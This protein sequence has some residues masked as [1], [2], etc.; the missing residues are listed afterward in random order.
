ML[1]GEA[2]ACLRQQLDWSIAATGKANGDR[3]GVYACYDIAVL[4]WDMERFRSAR[5]TV[6]WL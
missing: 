6:A 1:Y 4:F 2:E 5:D 3:D